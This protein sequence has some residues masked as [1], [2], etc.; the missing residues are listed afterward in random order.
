MNLQN[1]YK[2]LY[3]KTASDKRTFYAS[4]T[5]LFKDAGL[6]TEAT[7]GEYKLIYE[8]DG[9]IYGSVSGIPATGPEKDYCFDKF[10]IVFEDGYKVNSGES[11]ENDLPN[12]SDNLPDTSDEATI[13]VDKTTFNYGETITI[14]Y[15]NAVTGKDTETGKD[16]FDWIAITNGE[17]PD[18][19]TPSIQYAYVEGSGSVTFNDLEGTY[20][21]TAVDSDGD[22]NYDDTTVVYYNTREDVLPCLPA[23]TYGV[24]FLDDCGYTQVAGSPV[25]TIVV[26]EAE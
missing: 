19:D 1:G 7:I 20:G 10:G 11:N 18:Q 26:N 6:I 24:Y 3:E 14:N 25:L 8:K 16:K 23:G 15:T 17:K 5:G 13:T 2:V 21:R 12:D 9:K 22:A 4:E